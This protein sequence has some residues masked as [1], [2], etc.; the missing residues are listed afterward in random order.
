MMFCQPAALRTL[1]LVLA[2]GALAFAQSAKSGA[3][4]GHRYDDAHVLFYFTESTNDVNDPAR[5]PA[6]SPPL[7]RYGGSGGPVSSL[8]PERFA[9]MTLNPD[10]RLPIVRRFEL[11]LG[12]PATAQVEIE[13]LAE[14]PT[15]SDNFIG[16]I[17]RVVSNLDGY[18]GSRAKYYIV[19]EPGLPLPATT[20]AILRVRPQLNS[21]RLSATLDRR[22][23]VE[24]QRV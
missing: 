3:W 17:A 6:I 23:A 16:A 21:P 10:L 18:R 19:R 22:M 1:T 7:A 13:R 24:L 14:Q 4:V 2:A 12:G 5:G 9:G 11:L 15:C 8:D 20:S